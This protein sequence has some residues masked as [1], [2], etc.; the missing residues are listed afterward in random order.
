MQAAMPDRE[1]YQTDEPSSALSFPAATLLS[2]AARLTQI[3]LDVI[4]KLPGLDIDQVLQTRAN[5]KL[6]SETAW[7]IECACDAQIIASARNMRNTGRAGD[8][9]GLGKMSAVRR[10]SKKAG[11]TPQTIFKNA[12]IFRLIQQAESANP[13]MTTSLRIL[14][15]R[16]YFV[17]A[18]T[19][20]DP[21][22]ALYLFIEKKKTLSRF[23]TTDAERLLEREGLTKKAVLSSA[24]SNARDSIPELSTRAAELEHIEQTMELIRG[25]IDKCTSPEI[26]R[27]HESYIE[28]LRDYMTEYLFDIDASTALRRAWALGNHNNRQLAKA[29]GFTEDVVLREMRM[30]ASAGHFILI[31]RTEPPK[32]HKVGEPLPP[33]LR[34]K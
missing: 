33:E 29:T 10:Q 17:A 6:L 32:W 21:L 14:N 11:C 1:I 19:A 9:E 28:D 23:R 12:Q 24:I 25:Q 4:S 2:H 34:G 31:P 30:M 5:S 18:L 15:E 13:E 22:S 3:E 7:R 27:V 8:R 26:V 16:K 20:A